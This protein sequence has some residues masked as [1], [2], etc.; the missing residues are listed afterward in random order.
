VKIVRERKAFWEEH[1]RGWT[2]ARDRLPWIRR[3]LGDKE[4]AAIG[5]PL[6]A[7]KQ[8]RKQAADLFPEAR[9]M[10]DSPQFAFGPNGAVVERWLIPFPDES[11]SA[12]PK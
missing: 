8:L 3:L 2:E 4:Y 7:S 1:A 5:L 12:R 11:D 6:D 9:I 10:A